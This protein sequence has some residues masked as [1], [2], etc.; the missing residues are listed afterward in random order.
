MNILTY[1]NTPF[2]SFHCYVDGSLSFTSPEKDY[3]LVEVLGRDGTLAINNDRFRNIDIEIP[4]HIN[5]DFATNYRNLMAFLNAQNGYLKFEISIEPLHFRKALLQTLTEPTV[6]QSDRSGTFSIVF[7]AMPQRWLK[8]GEE[9][10]TFTSN[11]TITNPTLFDSKPIIR[12]F[13]AGQVGVGSE[14]ITLT[15]AG[16]SYVDV[17]CETMDAHEGATNFNQY[18]EVTDF[19]VLH[20]GSNGITLGTGVT[21]VEIQPRW[22]EI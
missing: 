1:N 18:L 10:T 19:P 12:I 16:T 22:Y 17:D 14:T 21:K 8:S 5:K 11:G 2:S 4:C 9:W 7:T 6:S 13:G 15:Q 3:E 20:S